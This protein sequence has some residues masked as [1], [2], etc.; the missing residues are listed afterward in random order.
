[1][2]SGPR[3]LPFVLFAYLALSLVLEA[4]P[5]VGGAP[6]PEPDLAGLALEDSLDPRQMDARQLRRLPGIGR[7]R[8]EAIVRARQARE[9]A[10]SRGGADPADTPLSWDDIRGIG[11]ITCER[12]EAWLVRHGGDPTLPLAE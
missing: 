6:L 4:G 11:P 8:A 2:S 1:V 10:S 5:F 9:L 12:I 7:V 3:V